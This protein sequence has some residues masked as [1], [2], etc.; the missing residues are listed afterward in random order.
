MDII[1]SIRNAFVPIHKAGYPFIAAFFVVAVVLGFLWE[2]LF[3]IGLILT[4]WCAYFFR[5]PERVTPIADHLAVSPA[6]G[7]VSLVGHV[8]PPAE[9]DLGTD[10]MLRIS[11]FMNVF[12]CHV[13]RAPMRGRIR[14][15]AY[16]EGEFRN[17]ELDKASE[18]NERNLMVIDGPKGEIGV[19]QIAGLVARR[20]ICW[21][22][23]EDRIEAGERFGL[24]RFGSRLDIYLPDGARPRVAEGQIAIAG[25]TVIAEFGDNLPTWPSRRD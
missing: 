8:V 19:V 11:V 14:H 1:A 21:A 24:I 20:I 6:D 4:A 7:R 13:N 9:L 15:I 3:W 25:E 5:D 2:P 23:V 22:K 10:P 16:R 17:A 18:V 12:N